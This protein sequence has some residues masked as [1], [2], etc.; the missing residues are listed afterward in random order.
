MLF[1]ENVQVA[2]VAARWS[3][4]CVKLR[5]LSSQIQSA[6]NA[7]RRLFGLRSTAALRKCET[8]HRRQHQRDADAD[9]IA[10]SARRA[11]SAA[12]KASSLLRRGAGLRHVP[13]AIAYADFIKWV[14]V[15]HEMGQAR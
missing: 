4:S 11:D 14:C 10:R 5:I 1:E 7:R 12:A 13:R 8:R 6:G 15:W 2:S 3:T 9:A